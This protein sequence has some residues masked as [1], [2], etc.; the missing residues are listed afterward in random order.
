MK[1]RKVKWHEPFCGAKT[2]LCKFSQWITKNNVKANIWKLYM[3]SEAD[4]EFM[5]NLSLHKQIILETMEKKEEA[6]NISFSLL[7]RLFLHCF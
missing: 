1:Q 5:E 4:K 2:S 3:K 7:T 6:E